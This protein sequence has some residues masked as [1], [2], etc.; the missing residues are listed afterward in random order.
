MRISA[1]ERAI[2]AADR[3]DDEEVD[4][5]CAR[6]AAITRAAIKAHLELEPDQPLGR[7]RHA[8]YGS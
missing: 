5:E 4:A 3:S 6:L 1:E 7:S 2:A 8:A